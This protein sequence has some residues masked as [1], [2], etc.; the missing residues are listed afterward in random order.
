ML[1]CLSI[2]FK[3]APLSI[4]EKVALSQ[5][6]ILRFFQEVK[7][8]CVILSTCNRLEI[9]F[10][11]SF[12]DIENTLGKIKKISRE[13]FVN[14]ERTYSDKSALRHLARV[15][16]GMD[17]MVLG[18]DEIL[19]QIKEA[20]YLS[21][22]ANKTNYEMNVIF[23]KIL[24][25]SK[26]IKTNTGLSSTPVSIGTLVANATVHFKEGKKKVLLMGI[27]G[28]IGT[29]IAK[30]LLSKKDVSLMATMRHHSFNGLQ[31]DNDIQM[32]P[33]QE[34]YQRI[35]EADV[36]ISATA[37]PHYTITKNEYIK[38][39]D[40][41]KKRLFI[42]LAVPSDIDP[43]LE[44]LELV[45]LM[46]IDDFK[47]L[48]SHNNEIK[49]QYAQDAD[50]MILEWVEEIQKE[51]RMH[52]LVQLLP[53]LNEDVQKGG[54]QHLLFS[55]REYTNYDQMNEIICWLEDYVKGRS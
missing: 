7:D 22:D 43:E 38:Y 53:V 36:I 47:E 20:Y 4:R 8:S 52:D 3:K 51:L 29:I 1:R 30:N 25:S 37:S 55:L 26:D 2:S 35:Q 23:Q 39:I 21:F 41:D 10:E 54:F 31:G 19:R 46:N 15:A 24:Q 9:Y 27:T 45:E 50:V 34:R 17:S 6:E 18:E 16:C 42:D 33:F 48:A 28:K 12:F 11:G 49:K 32:V 40:E 14:Y 13:E 44:S 5:E